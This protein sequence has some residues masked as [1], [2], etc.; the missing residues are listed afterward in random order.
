MTE[1]RRGNENAL[2]QPTNSEVRKGTK[3]MKSAI[4]LRDKGGYI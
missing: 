3:K 1:V 2:L 4:Y